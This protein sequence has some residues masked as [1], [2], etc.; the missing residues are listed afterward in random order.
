MEKFVA[1]SAATSP[2]KNGRKADELAEGVVL[3][4]HKDGRRDTE[5]RIAVQVLNR[6]LELG[7][8]ISV[9]SDE[10]RLG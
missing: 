7:Q 9:A 3:R 5:V 2:L 6:M 4:F 8:P 10:F 1:R